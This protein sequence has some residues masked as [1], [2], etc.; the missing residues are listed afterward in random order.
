MVISLASRSAS[1]MISSIGL[2]QNLAAFARLLGRPGRERGLRGVE[3]GLGVVDAWRSRPTRPRSRSPD[4]SRRSARRRSRQHQCSSTSTTS[5]QG[6]RFQQQAGASHRPAT[7]SRR[8]ACVVEMRGGG[9]AVVGELVVGAG[10]RRRWRRRR[11]RRRRWGWGWVR[12]RR[13]L[14]TRAG[15]AG[16][17]AL[18]ARS[19]AVDGIA[20]GPGLVLSCCF[21]SAYCLGTVCSEHHNSRSGR[22]GREWAGPTRLPTGQPRIGAGA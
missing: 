3:R 13:S 5:A 21:V 6:N 16:D 4:R 14:L 15:E 1:R 7:G 9:R 19:S 2:A 8:R 12:W 10:T 18:P 11:R 17:S 20:A 22:F